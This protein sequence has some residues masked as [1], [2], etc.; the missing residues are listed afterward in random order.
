MPYFGWMSVSEFIRLEWAYRHKNFRFHYVDTTEA[1]AKVSNIWL[2]SLYFNAYRWFKEQKLNRLLRAA[3]T[4][5]KSIEIVDVLRHMTSLHYIYCIR[6]A[7][8]VQRNKALIA[9][10]S[11]ISLEYCCPKQSTIEQIYEVN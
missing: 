1:W 7:G 4:L 3:T 10:L 5:L 6:F 11:R 9:Q 8:S 2:S